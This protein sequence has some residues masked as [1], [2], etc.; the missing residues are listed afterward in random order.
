[1][2]AGLS[3]SAESASLSPAHVTW[4]LNSGE[5]AG[6]SLQPASHWHGESQPGSLAFGSE[7][8]LAISRLQTS[9]QRSDH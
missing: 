1:M 9:A 8:D 6:P 3:R 4:Q 2:T 7:S 5:S